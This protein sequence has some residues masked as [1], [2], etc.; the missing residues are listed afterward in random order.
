MAE[1]SS[2]INVSR[3]EIVVSYAFRKFFREGKLNA[4]HRQSRPIKQRMDDAGM[5]TN[6]NKSAAAVRTFIDGNTDSRSVHS[7]IIAK[8]AVLPFSNHAI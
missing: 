7:Q 3:A 6:E 8:L 5:Y 2:T 4:R 1:I